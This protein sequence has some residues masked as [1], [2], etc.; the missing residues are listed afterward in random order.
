MWKHAAR[1]LRKI[2]DYDLNRTRL[3]LLSGEDTLWLS[4]QTAGKI[5][6]DWGI[7][8]PYMGIVLTTVVNK[9]PTGQR[10]AFERK[11][12][13]LRRSLLVHLAGA[14]PEA[15]MASAVERISAYGK[16]QNC[17][18]LFVKARK[19][20]RQY[21]TH[22]W[23]PDWELVAYTRDRPT[24]PLNKSHYPGWNKVGCYRI[25]QPLYRKMRDPQ[26]YQSGTMCYFQAHDYHGDV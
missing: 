16:E 12:P 5:N 9:P 6:S 4:I 26:D 23:A 22:F 24:K 11:D 7:P 13:A 17:R 1:W 15:W 20:W 19:R 8:M 3:R 14:S 10:K 25:M 21:A 18:M 2:P